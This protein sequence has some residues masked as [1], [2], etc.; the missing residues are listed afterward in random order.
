MTIQWS[1]VAAARQP[2]VAVVE[3]LG[4]DR[5]LTPT[6]LRPSVCLRP[7]VVRAA[8]AVYDRHFGRFCGAR[9]DP[10]FWQLEHPAVWR[11]MP[12][13]TDGTP[14]VIVGT[15]PSLRAGLDELRRHRD[16]IHVVTSPRG[17]DVLEDAGLVPDVVLIEHQTPVDAQFSVHARTERR[18]HW[19]TQVSLVVTDGRTPLSLVADVPCDRLVNLD[20]LPTWGL[21]PATAAAMAVSCGARAVALLGV[22]L[23]ALERPDP[24]HDALRDLLS[25]VVM[26]SSVTC[27]DLGIGGSSKIGW[28]PGHLTA[29]LD[30][31]GRRH[32]LGLARVPTR[33]IEE[34]REAAATASRHAAPVADVARVALDAAGRVRDGDRT[35][36]A[37][38]DLARSVAQ[39]LAHGQDPSIRQAVQD[40]LG[41]AFLPRYW[42]TPPDLALGAALW[43]PAALAAHEVVHQHHAL[44]RRIGIGGGTA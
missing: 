37:I 2:A 9:L 39:L 23:G 30:C 12:I 13:V 21:W 4:R 8:W 24:R 41:C 18:R 27:V 5:A 43:R 36:G 34:R 14:M 33:P 7:D 32:P 28:L 40:G 44:E 20:P 25:L 3:E 29:I 1:A 6:E 10:Q 19:P 38:A 26:G 35:P 31:A 22:D 11:G 17:A 16:R 15:G 42:R